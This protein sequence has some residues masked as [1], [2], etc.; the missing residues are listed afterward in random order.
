METDNQHYHKPVKRFTSDKETA[1]RPETEWINE[2]DFREIAARKSNELLYLAHQVRACD[3]LNTLLTRPFFGRMHYEAA[4]VEEMLDAYNARNNDYWSRFR[5]LVAAAKVFTDVGYMFRHLQYTAPDYRLL[6]IDQD[7][8][9]ET[10]HAM[11][12]ILE[13]IGRISNELLLEAAKLQMNPDPDLFKYIAFEETLV[14]ARL[15]QTRQPRRTESPGKTVVHLATVF[16]NQSEESQLLEIHRKVSRNEYASCIPDTVSEKDLRLIEGRFHN[17]Q[18]IYDTYISDSNFES[19]NSDLPV[20]RGHV[21][22]IFHLMEIA[23]RLAHYYE[24]HM[25][26]LGRYFKENSE[27][28]I[29]AADLLDI[30]MGYNISFANLFLKTG[31][32]LCRHM[33]QEYAE[34]GEILVP[35]PA[36]RGFHVRPSTLVAKIVIHYGSKVFLEFDGTMYDA[37]S[38]LE[39]F[40]VN[41]RINA[42]K[43]QKVAEHIVNLPVL[44]QLAD[45]EIQESTLGVVLMGLWEQEK[46]VLYDGSIS[47]DDF[48]SFEGETLAE[49]AKRGLAHLL[50]MGRIDI[51]TDIKAK[52]I[53]DKRV[54]E[55]IRLLANHGYGE[56]NFGNDIVLP[57][58][59]SYLRR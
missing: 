8:F 11:T 58:E 39:L 41:E 52:F 4:K 56:D 12:V 53:G 10:Q 51:R 48:P 38:P 28:L 22:I 42:I 37:S 55:D 3:D 24:R 40:R 47:I 5:S 34:Q 23:T 46:V 7:F 30:L 29:S 54:L 1:G 33:I 26:V 27:K 35:V 21:S 13:T 15:P 31:Q 43:R 25:T 17:L 16:L 50:A 36:Y 6:P 49:Y 18:S 9:S 20:L 59:L 44:K 14:H 57:R 2:Q 45:A 32:N 19:Q